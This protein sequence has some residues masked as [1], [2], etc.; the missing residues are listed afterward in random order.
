M[1]R[2]GICLIVC[3]VV[4][5]SGFA[6][7]AAE[8]YQ[9]PTGFPSGFNA[10]KDVMKGVPVGGYGGGAGAITHNPVIFVHGNTRAGDDWLPNY[11]FFLSKGYTPNE[12]WAISYGNKSLNNIDANDENIADINGFIQEVLRYT[13]TINPNVTKVDIISHSMGP[14]LVRK[15]IKVYHLE[16]VVGTHVMIAGGNHGM[17]L[18]SPGINSVCNELYPNSPWLNALNSPVENPAPIKHV[19][20][21]DGTG[22][23]D[24]GFLGD[25]IKNSPAINGGINHPIN[26]EQNL[27]LGHDP[28]RTDPASMQLQYESVKDDLVEP[29]KPA[30]NK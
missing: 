2:I 5:L 19:T 15:A 9:V 24:T 25:R 28:L 1:R 17:E 18:C 26:I 6:I 22:K 23:Y 13:Q 27:K 7:A 30:D 21:Y 8:E 29:V 11:K 12:L 14:T 16:E 10:P 4:V 20:I 3:I